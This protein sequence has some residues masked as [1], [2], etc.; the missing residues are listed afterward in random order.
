MIDLSNNNAKGHNFAKIVHSGHQRRVYLKR[1]EDRAFVDPDFE[2]LRAQAHRV[3]M[4][5]GGYHFAHPLAVTPKESFGFFMK[6]EPHYRRNDLRVAL[7]LEYGSASRAV[8]KWAEE[9]VKLHKKEHGF[10]PVIYVGY[11]YAAACDFEKFMAAVPLWLPA[12]G[13]NDG[14]EYPALRPAPWHKTAAHQYTSQALVPGVNGRCD[15][16]HVYSARLIDVPHPAKRKAAKLVGIG[17]KI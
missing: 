17:G 15:L 13:R 14:K 5:V 11:Y 2:S 3:G 4:K 12:Y 16:S 8:G 10:F 6:H 1:S 9:W 7:D